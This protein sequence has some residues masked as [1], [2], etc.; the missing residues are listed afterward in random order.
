MHPL[1]YYFGTPDSDSGDDTY[2]P[3]PS[4]SISMELSRRIRRMSQP[5]GEGTRHLRSSSLLSGMRLNSLR[6][7]E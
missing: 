6:I 2:D 3:T 1:Y 5:L 4:A 7:K